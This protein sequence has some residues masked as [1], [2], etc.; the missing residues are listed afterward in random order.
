LELTFRSPYP[1]HFEVVELSSG[2]YI[3]FLHTVVW[4]LLH[5]SISTDRARR[6]QMPL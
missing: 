5:A 1:Q 3:V 4:P 6:P 2:Q